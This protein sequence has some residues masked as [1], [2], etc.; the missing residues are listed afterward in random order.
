MTKLNRNQ[1]VWEGW[2]IGHIID[3]LK[4]TMD[5]I[6]QGN[7]FYKPFHDVN[8]LTDFIKKEYPLNQFRGNVRA[9]KAVAKYF[10][11]DYHIS[12]MAVKGRE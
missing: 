11:E 7:S 2:T 8:E 1:E 9:A 5:T 10:A 4:P 12:K 3:N 6:M